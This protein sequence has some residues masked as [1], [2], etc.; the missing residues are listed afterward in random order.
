[1]TYVCGAGSSMS[2]VS[3]GGSPRLRRAVSRDPAAARAPPG[4]PAPAHD[5]DKG[6]GHTDCVFTSYT[7]RRG[8]AVITANPLSAT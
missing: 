7:D 3:M 4:P 5:Q 6:Y 2:D 8:V 1:M